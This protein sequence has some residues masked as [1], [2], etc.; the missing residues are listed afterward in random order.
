MLSFAT[1]THD[2]TWTN[3][4]GRGAGR[5]AASE[6]LFVCRRGAVLIAGEQLPRAGP[7]CHNDVIDN[8]VRRH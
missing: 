6:S 1:K 4:K 8:S 5:D 2:A 7:G 3:L